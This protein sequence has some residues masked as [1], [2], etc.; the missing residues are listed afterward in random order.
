MTLKVRRILSSFFILLFLIIAPAIVLYAAGFKL[1]KNGFS[2]QKTGMFI[3]D[4]NPRGAKIFINGEVQRNFFSSL[5]NKNSFIVTP[6][7]IKNLLPGEYDLTLEL[8]GYSGWQKKLAISPGSSTSVENIYLFKNNLPVQIFPASI[9]SVNL[10]PDKNRALILSAEEL[11]LFNLADET[12]KTAGQNGLKGK[13]IFWSPDGEKVVI[14]NSLY[15]LNNLS[16]RI[17][18]SKLTANPFNYKWSDNSLYFQDR[19]SLYRLNNK[20]LPEKIIG[21][22]QF[23]DY[24]IKGRYLYLIEQAAQAGSLEIIDLPSKKQI[25]NINLPSSANYYFINPEQELINLYDNNHKILY[26]IDPLAAYYSPLV[27]IINNLKTASWIDDNNL[28]YAGDYE[29]WLYSLETK[30]KTL[31]TR[32]SETINSAVMHPNK[33]Y[34]IYATSQTINA[35][36]LDGR[37]KRN[38]AELVKFD[39]IESFALNA[40]GDTLYFFGK[41]GNAEGLYKLSIQ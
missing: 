38:T 7:K 33:N 32:L 30:G 36:E 2:I 34:I 41:I 31:I 23:N 17:D 5:L 20:N 1:A 14:D 15:D 39:S 16:S 12:K 24:L 35:I 19:T 10:S 18:L 37:E 21:Q 6:A 22:I 8:N 4:S 28:L 40:R 11:T 9:E 27:E 29:I 25:K 13:N 3:I 26:L